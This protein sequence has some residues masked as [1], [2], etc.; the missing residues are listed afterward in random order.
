MI[1]ALWML[2]RLKMAGHYTSGRPDDQHAVD[3][4]QQAAGNDAPIVE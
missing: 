2:A 1:E 3:T 4:G